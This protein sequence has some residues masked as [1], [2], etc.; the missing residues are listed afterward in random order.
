MHD[1]D[2]LGLVSEYKIKA[3]AKGKEKRVETRPQTPRSRKQE[4]D[5]LRKS[6]LPPLICHVVGVEQLMARDSLARSRDFEAT[7][8]DRMWAEQQKQR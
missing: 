1:K 8:M 3:K 2:K 4:L 6:P 5:H 7:L